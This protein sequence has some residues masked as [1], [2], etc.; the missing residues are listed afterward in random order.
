MSRPEPTA[1]VIGYGNPGRLDDGLGPALAAQLAALHLPGVA[2][3]TGYQLTVEDAELVARHDVVV[4]A[5]AAVSGPAPFDFRPIDPERGAAFTT[6]SVAP[7]IV[8]GL[9]HDL[10]DAT[11]AGYLLAI[12]GSEFDEFGERLSRAAQDHLA[13]ALATLRPVLAGREPFPPP[14]APRATT[15]EG[16]V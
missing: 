13:A 11:T 14:R 5:D 3:E 16:V 9:A 10:F 15:S 6:H 7:E 8:L 2:V 12:R 4:F 1:L